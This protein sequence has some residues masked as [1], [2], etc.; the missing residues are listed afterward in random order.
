MAEALL[1]KDIV[2]K[3]RHSEAIEALEEKFK[4]GVKAAR[5]IGKTSTEAVEEL[6]ED[7][8]RQIKRH[9]AGYVVGAFG[10]GV[11]LGGL[12]GFFIRRK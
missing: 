10:V 3:V 11:L 8:T 9:P 7:T 6:L 2:E 4:D 1:E 5:K 12:L